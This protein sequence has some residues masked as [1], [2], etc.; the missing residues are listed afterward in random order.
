[1]AA[2][3][4]AACVRAWTSSAARARTASGVNAGTAADPTEGPAVPGPST[5]RLVARATRPG[6]R[7]ATAA[8]SAAAEDAPPA[9]GSPGGVDL[10]GLDVGHHRRAHRV[11]VVLGLVEHRRRRPVVQPWWLDRCG[12]ADQ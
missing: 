3:R 5:P 11:E 1:M 10:L 2:A 8:P 7:P 4:S 9:L 6:R 12:R